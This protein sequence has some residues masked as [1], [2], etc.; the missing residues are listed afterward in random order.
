[1]PRPPLIRSDSL[2]YHVTV[3]SNNREWFHIPIDRVW[4]VLT[5]NIGQAAWKYGAEIH[6]LLLMSNHFHLLLSTPKKN[7]D[8]V[9]RYSLSGATRHIGLLAK[10]ENHVFGARYKPTIL[11]DARALAYVYKYICRN[12]VRAGIASKVEGYQ[13]SSLN[14]LNTWMPVVEG[15]EAYWQGIPKDRRER[16]AWLNLPTHKEQEA[17]I[18]RGLRRGRFA[19]SKDNNCKT[20]LTLLESAYQIVTPNLE[21]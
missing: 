3:R 8:A 10:R 18:T 1:M 21:S 6:T 13:F 5:R 17:L 4:D 16:V 2:A 11:P 12:P 20:A 15:F 19:F 7:I 14:S 9:M